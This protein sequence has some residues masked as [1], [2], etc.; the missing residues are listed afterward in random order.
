MRDIARITIILGSE[1]GAG[2]SKAYKLPWIDSFGKLICGI[3][4]PCDEVI[5]CL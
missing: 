4:I 3:V 1:S 2:G 5:K